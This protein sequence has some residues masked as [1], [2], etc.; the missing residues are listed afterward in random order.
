[1]QQ[2]GSRGFQR[3]A[4]CTP[5]EYFA[6]SPTFMS[7]MALQ[8]ISIAAKLN[9]PAGF[10]RQT[11]TAPQTSKE[12]EVLS[13]S[14]LSEVLFDQLSYL[15]QYADQERHRLGRVKAILLETFN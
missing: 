11:D 4:G 3:A 2:S 6:A 14:E 12:P 1:M 5:A 9:D 7:G 10:V 15:I 13:G 8:L